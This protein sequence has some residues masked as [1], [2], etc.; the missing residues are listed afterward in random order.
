MEERLR[1]QILESILFK[2]ASWFDKA[3]SKPET[4]TQLLTKDVNWLVEASLKREFLTFEIIW[5]IL[6]TLGL[7]V[8]V[9]WKAAILL[10]VLS[11]ILI[12][13]AY[14]FKILLTSDNSAPIVNSSKA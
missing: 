12:V 9:D 1:S 2:Q 14:D 13:I 5:C 8:Y 10:S 3:T 6:A 11:I 7:C 4:L